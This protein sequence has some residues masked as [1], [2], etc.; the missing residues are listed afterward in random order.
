MGLVHRQAR[1]P[2]SG[3]GCP[4]M[5]AM[6]GVSLNTARE[7]PRDRAEQQ[8]RI[9]GS[10]PGGQGPGSSRHRQHASRQVKRIAR[11][12]HSSP[13]LVLLELHVTW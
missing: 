1:I 12:S 3:F 7:R 8:S 13:L 4:K 9:Y 5:H 10:R 2:I 11:P 6:V